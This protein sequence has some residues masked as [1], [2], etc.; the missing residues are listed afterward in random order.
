ML[1]IF[2]K[3]LVN[4][5]KELHSPASVSSSRKPKLPVEILEDFLSANPNNAFSIGFGAAASL[6]Y[7]PQQNSCTTYQRYLFLFP[8]M[9]INYTRTNPPFFV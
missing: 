5:P 8:Y 2:N 9:H 3:G 1:A 7:V 4:P 6:A